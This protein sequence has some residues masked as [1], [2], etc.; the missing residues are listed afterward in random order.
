[1]RHTRKDRRARVRRET[2]ELL[3]KAL[4]LLAADHELVKNWRAVRWQ[5]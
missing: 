3:D 2:L 4:G 5:R 1:M